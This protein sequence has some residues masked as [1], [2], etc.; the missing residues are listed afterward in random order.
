MHTNAKDTISQTSFRYAVH[1]DAD[2]L[3]VKKSHTISR[4]F[5]GQILERTISIYFLFLYLLSF[6][7]DLYPSGKSYG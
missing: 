3:A 5:K 1:K 2:S 7:S 6:K 4:I